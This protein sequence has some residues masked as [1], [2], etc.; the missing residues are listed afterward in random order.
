MTSTSLVHLVHLHLAV[1]ETTV[2]AEDWSGP[3]VFRSGIEGRVA[4][5]NVAADR[6]LADRHLEPVAALEVDRET[7]LLDVVTRQSRVHIAMASRTRVTVGDAGVVEVER[8]L[9]HDDPAYVGREYVLELRAGQPVTI[10]KV[11]AVA[12]S[13]DPAGLVPVPS[14]PRPTGSPKRPLHPT[15]LGTP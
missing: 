14:C 10:E 7:V 12:T 8:R 5:R 15:P 1:L 2:E 3:L 13:R 4:N 11:V 9:L 6:F